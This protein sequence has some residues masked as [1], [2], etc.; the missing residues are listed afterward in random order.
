MKNKINEVV[1]TFRDFDDSRINLECLQF[2]IRKFSRDTAIKL[3][4]QGNSKEK[5]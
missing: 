3:A 1:I 4:N 5:I 2:K